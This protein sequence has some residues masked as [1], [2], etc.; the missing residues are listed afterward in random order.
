MAE[1]Q[2]RLITV[3]AARD[4]LRISRARMTELIAKG[5]LPTQPSPL[6]GRV[7]LVKLSD[8]EAL[9]RQAGREIDEG[10]SDA[11]A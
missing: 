11:A 1:G 6:D 7:K 10:K 3:G 2:D 8:V 4:M 9:A 5:T